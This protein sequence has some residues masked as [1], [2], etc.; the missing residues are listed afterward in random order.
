MIF[1]ILALLISFIISAIAIYF[2]VTGWV[3]LFSSAAFGVTLMFGAIEIGK[4]V[5]AGFLHWHWKSLPFLIKWTLTPMVLVTML[6][7]SIGVYG[8]LSKGHLDQELPSTTASSQ[9]ELIDNQLRIQERS[10]ERSEKVIVTNEA[11]EDGLQSILD[12]LIDFDRINDNRNGKGALTIENEQRPERAAISTNIDNAQSKIEAAA[13]KIGAL[14]LQRLE[15][16]QQINAVEAKLGPMR[17]IVDLL[18]IE[19]DDSA[20]QLIIV[21]VMFVFDPFAV[22]LLLAGLWSFKI[23]VEK[24]PKNVVKKRTATATKITPMSDAEF[25]QKVSEPVEDIDP[26]VEAMMDEAEVLKK[27]ESRLRKGWLK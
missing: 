15:Y 23:R 14:Q 7:T 18:Q 4:L 2:S 1:G 3:A 16:S 19:N 12:T 21:L 25:I 26:V 10:I 6:I 20:V 11:R 17:Y 5:A 22:A 8:F 13:N 27:N 24:P 9:I